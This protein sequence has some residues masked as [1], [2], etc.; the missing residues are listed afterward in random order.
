M[1][2]FGIFKLLYWSR[3]ITQVRV[4]ASGIRQKY[5]GLGLDALFYHR[6]F[7]YAETIGQQRGECSWIL[8]DNDVMNAAMEKMGAVR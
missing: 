1:P 2:P 5:R 3:K 4:L 6:T 7:R 8:E